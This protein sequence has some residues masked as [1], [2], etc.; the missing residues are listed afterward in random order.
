MDW[1]GAESIFGGIARMNETMTFLRTY[2]LQIGMIVLSLIIGG[3]LAQQ[4]SVLR[5]RSLS[6]KLARFSLALLF[7]A[8]YYAVFF[9]LGVIFRH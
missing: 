3:N 1:N 2:W 5:Q 4:F 7:S 8:L 9:Y 6:G